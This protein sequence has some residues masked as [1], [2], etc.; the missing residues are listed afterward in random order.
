M[1]KA[2]AADE[3]SDSQ[4]SQGTEEEAQRRAAIEES[5]RKL[6]ELEKDRPL[7]EAEACKRQAQERAE[8]AARQAKKEEQR[9]QAE[10][11]ETQA[12]RQREAAQAEADRKARIERDRTR[13]E[14]QQAQKRKEA[15]RQRWSYGPWTPQRALE[16]YRTLCE[17]FDSAK[18]SPETPATLDAI[19]WP[20]LHS[21]VTLS[22]EDIEWA[23]VESFFRSARTL[24][25]TQ[26]YKTFV[27][28]S[29][30]RFH[31]DR[32]RARGILR[33]VQDEELRGCLEVAANT[34]AQAI[35]PLWREVKG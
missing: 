18:F 26:D 2:P 29:H 7:W 12:R 11:A 24:M 27:N 10:R 14:Q 32:W 5:K 30:K 17:S 34:V 6:A 33:T 19:P 31:P 35:T 20:V 1:L 4:E 13:W 9:K 21:P 3:E 15:Q 23:A 8:E 22:V 16:R 25:R 28:E